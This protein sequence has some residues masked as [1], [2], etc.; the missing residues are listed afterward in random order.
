M[1]HQTSSSYKLFFQKVY[2]PGHPSQYRCSGSLK[3]QAY[4]EANHRI[5]RKWLNKLELQP[6]FI[7]ELGCGGGALSAVHPAWI[8]LEFSLEALSS[9]G[10]QNR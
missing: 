9:L 5:T 1:S 7:L 2:E 3:C 8:G 10:G 4:H 6:H